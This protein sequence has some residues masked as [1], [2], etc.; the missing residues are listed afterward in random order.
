MP[1]KGKISMTCSSFKES[2]S[3]VRECKYITFVNALNNYLLNALCV[4]QDSV[5]PKKTMMNKRKFGPRL[6]GA[7]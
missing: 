2:H 1:D 3:G 4:C 6:H 5:D 7:S